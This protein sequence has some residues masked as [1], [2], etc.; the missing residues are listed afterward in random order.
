M[1]HHLGAEIATVDI[2]AGYDAVVAVDVDGT[3]WTMVLCVIPSSTLA[4]RLPHGQGW[5]AIVHV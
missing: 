2:A 5:P 3:Q 1:A 4:E